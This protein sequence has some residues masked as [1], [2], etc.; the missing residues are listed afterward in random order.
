MAKTKPYRVGEK[1]IIHKLALA[2]LAADIEKGVIKPQFEKET[3]KPYKDKGGY[4][5]IYLKSDPKAKRAWKALQR[6][7]RKVHADYLA[8]S[9]KEKVNGRP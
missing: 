7:V 8:Y 3:G 2:L 4:L 6:E 1:E 5:D 9:K